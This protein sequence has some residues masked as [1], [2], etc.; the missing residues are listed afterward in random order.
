M[1]NTVELHFECAECGAELDGES[2]WRSPRKRY[3]TTFAISPCENCLKRAREEVR[4][5]EDD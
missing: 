1:A 5:S 3:D 2:E 4:E